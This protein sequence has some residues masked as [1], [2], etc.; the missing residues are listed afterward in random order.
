MPTLLRA[1][2]RGGRIAG[3]DGGWDRDGGYLYGA[4]RPTFLPA[5][6]T[7]PG[8]TNPMTKVDSDSGNPISRER[9]FERSRAV[10][11]YLFESPFFMRRITCPKT[12]S[13][14]LQPPQRL[15]SAGR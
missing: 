2:L 9:V 10:P 4:R 6:T 13:E 12:R 14:M 15:W 8:G 1:S 7:H 11:E 5:W 3:E